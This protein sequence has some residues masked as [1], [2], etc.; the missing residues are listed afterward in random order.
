MLANWALGHK[1]LKKKIAWRLYQEQDLRKAAFLLASSEF[2]QRDVEALL[3]DS[4]VVI[5]PNGCDA[6]PDEYP[7]QEILPPYP[8][9][10]WAVAMGRLHPVKGYA[11]LI[12]AWAGLAPVGWNLA[13]AG[14][15]E[16][17]YRATLESLIKKHQMQDSI[18]LLGEIP[19]AAKWSLFDQCELFVAPSKTENF[20][21]AIAEALQSGTPV[22]TTTG[23]PW[24][25]LI[26]RDCGWWIE[27]EAR[28]LEQT[29]REATSCPPE[30]L[31][32][33]GANGRSLVREKY[34]WERV[35]IRTIELYQMALSSKNQ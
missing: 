28:A 8:N 27:N 10:R 5:V 24:R 11:G 14:P 19:D 7:K 9:V 13:I 17:G 26:E 22:I 23:T 32:Q 1:A 34:T 33:K 12:E 20:G 25:E 30:I 29:L 6:A 2:E 21:M 3:P 18:F 31:R 4:R 35:A 15:D 16:A